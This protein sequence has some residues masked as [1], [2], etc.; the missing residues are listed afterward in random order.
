MSHG[1][2]D[3][4]GCGEPC[5]E[6]AHYCGSCGQRVDPVGQAGDDGDHRKGRANRSMAWL[7]AFVLVLIGAFVF[8]ILMH[9]SSVVTGSAGPSPMTSADGSGGGSALAAPGTVVPCVLQEGGSALVDFQGVDTAQCTQYAQQLSGNG[10]FWELNGPGL[11]NPSVY[12]VMQTGGGSIQASVQGYAGGDFWAGD[13]CSALEQ[14]GW[15][16]APA[17]P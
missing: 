5:G 6:G 8:E 3:C 2:A 1:Q 17:A 16:Q 12:C 15:T 10:S 14:N 4:P 13:V 7:T 9:K 11:K